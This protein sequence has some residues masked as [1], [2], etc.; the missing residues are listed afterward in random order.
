MSG[1]LKR[2]N[3]VLARCMRAFCV[4]ALI[5]FGATVETA[6]PSNTHLLYL[7][8]DVVLTLWAGLLYRIATRRWM[9]N[10][11]D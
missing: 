6:H 5:P 4:L 9:G 10:G 3:V 11:D 1:D 7:G 8:G 2:R